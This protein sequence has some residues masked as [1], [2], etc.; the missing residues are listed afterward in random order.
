MTR[1]SSI[2][3]LQLI[4]YFFINCYPAYSCGMFACFILSFMYQVLFRYYFLY[5]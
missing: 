3:K 2:L 5:M 1:F 4:Q